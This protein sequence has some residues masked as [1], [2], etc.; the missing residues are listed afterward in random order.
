MPVQSGLA[1]S[2]PLPADPSPLP[3]SSLSRAGS[4]RARRFGRG[5]SGHSPWHA[6]LLQSPGE[7]AAG[8][9]GTHCGLWPDPAGIFLRSYGRESRAR[10]G[11][12]V[13]DAG[14]PCAKE[15]EWTKHQKCP[16]PHAC[17]VKT[18][19][20]C[21]FPPQDPPPLLLTASGA[22]CWVLCSLLCSPPPPPQVQKTSPHG[23]T[24]LG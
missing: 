22:P 15:A 8:V 10:S 13:Q 18:G 20:P 6:A 14:S 2:E 16:P 21:H 24:W 7:K 1:G 17:L 23:T 9:G 11:G 12:G 5:R 3:A 4:S 19:P